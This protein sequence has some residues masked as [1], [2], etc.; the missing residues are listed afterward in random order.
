MTKLLLLAIIS[1]CLLAFA[2]EV[3][4]RRPRRGWRQRL[5]DAA[6]DFRQGFL[7]GYRGES[8][9]GQPTLAG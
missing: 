9:L 5:S 8:R 7:E 6:R 3:V 2:S 1:A 4:G